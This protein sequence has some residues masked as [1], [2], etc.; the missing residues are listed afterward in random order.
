MITYK[1]SFLVFFVFFSIPN[2]YGEIYSNE[3]YGFSIDIPEGGIINDNVVKVEGNS[4]FESSDI[5]LSFQDG[6]D[7]FNHYFEITFVKND[8]IA[9]NYSGE[10]YLD[11]IIP[12]LQN[13]CLFTSFEI[14]G[15]L[16]TSHSILFE[17]ILEH[18]GNPAYQITESWIEV[19]PDQTSI[20]ITSIIRDIVVNGNVWNISSINS[21]QKYAEE[22]EMI[23]EIFNSF[24]LEST[25]QKIPGAKNNFEGHHLKSPKHQTSEGIEPN[26]V[27]CKVGLELIFKSTDNSPACVKPE[28][29]EKLIQRNWTYKVQ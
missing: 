23:L 15:R 26:E 9:L 25:E 22:Y 16:C 6:E 21:N 1:I 2:I 18:K 14:Q 28:T 8:T 7:S 13:N 19:Y 5:V 4:N 12:Q 3:E 10:E 27:R 17:E 24:E 29:A 11:K 20:L